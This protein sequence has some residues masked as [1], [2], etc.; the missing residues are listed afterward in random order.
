MASEKKTLSPIA[1]GFICRDSIYMSSKS[2]LFLLYIREQQILFK[3]VLM[4][5]NLMGSNLVKLGG[6][7]CNKRQTC[8]VKAFEMFFGGSM[9]VCCFGFQY[10]SP[11]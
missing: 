9:Y 5:E 1:N 3:V 2:V 11:L 8:Q 6:K 7:T 10:I 4:S